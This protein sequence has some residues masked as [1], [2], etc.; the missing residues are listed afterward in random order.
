VREDRKALLADPQT[1]AR[2]EALT[3]PPLRS[4]MVR[5]FMMSAITT[6]SVYSPED[7]E[8]GLT[9]LILAGSSPKAS[10]VTGIPEATL[11]AWKRDHSERYEQ[12]QDELEPRIVKKIAAEA[13]NIVLRL[14]HI[15]HKAIDQLEGNIDELKPAELAAASRNLA[16]TSALYIDKHS[17]PL[18][19][20]PSHVQQGR[21]LD[22]VVVS[23]MARLVGFDATSTA[24]RSWML[25]LR[26]CRS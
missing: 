10:E 14:A 2:S 21:D 17:S 11:R 13:E 26:Q 8:R 22:Q 24:L 3:S 12:L 25:S 16:T 18:R 20:R 15:Q 1:L 9:A 19:E 4:M 6:R 5:A 7:R 23:A